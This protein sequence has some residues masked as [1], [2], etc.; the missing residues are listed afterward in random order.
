MISNRSGKVCV[1]AACSFDGEEVIAH[2]KPRLAQL[3]E[4]IG[5]YSI[6]AL[7]MMRMS[8]EPYRYVES[9][10][11][12]PKSSTRRRLGALIHIA[13]GIPLYSAAAISS[14]SYVSEAGEAI[15]RNIFKT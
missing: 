8:A 14:V 4:R 15:V 6:G 3:H 12:L 2:A 9:D 11:P 1:E 7:Y 13:A 5:A 10:P